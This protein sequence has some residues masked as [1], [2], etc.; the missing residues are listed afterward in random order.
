MRLTAPVATGLA[1]LALT[2]AALAV[3]CAQAPSMAPGSRV[4]L[5]AH[6]AYPYDGRFSDRLA[7][8]LATGVP[9]ALE[10]D[11]IWR[12]GPDGRG[13][14]VVAHDE[15]KV[16]DAPTFES[17]FFGT[18][19]PVMQRALADNQRERWPLIVLNLDFKTNE[20]AH[21][22]RVLQVLRAH[23]TWLTRAT[24]TATPDTPAPLTIGPLLV[25]TGSNVVQQQSFHDNLK[26][27]EPLWLFGAYE[28][29]PAP[30]STAAERALALARLPPETL[31]PARAT[32]Y[33]RWVN[34][35][36]LVV[37][38]GG[39]NQA[40][41]WTAADRARLD[42]LVSRA[43]AQ[44]LFI[45]FYTLNGH[46]PAEAEAQGWSRTYNF[47]S[48]ANAALRWKAAREAKVDFIA[49]DQYEAFARAR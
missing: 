27:G 17:Y 15:D 21:H 34:F 8:G 3:P 7:R 5:D 25:L 9:V 22:A 35:P 11:L 23:E 1:A 28:A 6:N 4:L 12:V 37:E 2:C 14:S 38:S 36:W 31:M 20:P 24:R 33:R 10:Q 32:N 44:G 26:E 46:P 41:G 49:T 18:I 16:A 39:P 47:G 40:D 45:R 29:P 42:A 43:H 30:G 48:L 13:E 19:G